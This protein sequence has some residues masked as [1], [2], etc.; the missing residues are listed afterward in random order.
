[1]ISIAICG[2]QTIN[3]LR[4]QPSTGH[5]EDL[6]DTQLQS[7]GPVRLTCL[8]LPR[9]LVLERLSRLNLPGDLPVQ[10]FQEVNVP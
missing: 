9:N 2:G 5:A 6:G 8:D 3:E 1:M 4:L 7:A 10:G